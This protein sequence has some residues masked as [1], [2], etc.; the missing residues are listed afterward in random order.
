MREITIQEVEL[1]NGGKTDAGCTTITV[2]QNP[3]G[4]K[5]TTVNH[6][7]HISHS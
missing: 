4:T 5:T 6:G 3:D 2:T 7:C 1:V